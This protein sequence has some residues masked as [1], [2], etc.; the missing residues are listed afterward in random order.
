MVKYVWVSQRYCLFE[1]DFEQQFEAQVAISSA[2]SLFSERTPT[3]CGMDLALRG[4]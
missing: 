2:N 1:R 4:L 3:E